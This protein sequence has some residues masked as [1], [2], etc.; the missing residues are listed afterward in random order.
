MTV[1]EICGCG[2]TNIRVINDGTERKEEFP[3]ICQACE[4]ADGDYNNRPHWKYKPAPMGEH[5]SQ[6]AQ[7]RPPARAA[8]PSKAGRAA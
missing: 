5:V 2:N 6:S 7:H 3:T 1:L 8:H 4:Q